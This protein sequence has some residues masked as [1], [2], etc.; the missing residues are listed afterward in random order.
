M[1]KSKSK[2]SESSSSTKSAA[3]KPPA[4]STE[5]AAPAAPI[6]D[7]DLAA[8][9]AAKLL[10]ARVPAGSTTTG[11]SAA[12]ESAAFRNLKDS[13]AK[14]ASSTVA[15]LLDKSSIAGKHK[16]QTPFFGGKKVGHNQTFGADVN[17]SS[18]PRRTG[19]G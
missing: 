13:L 3:A 1:A 15:G 11:A 17:R 6:F 9:A 14:P 10:V 5:S 16:S 2:K 18:V 4:K 19:G 12:P 8:K 7:T